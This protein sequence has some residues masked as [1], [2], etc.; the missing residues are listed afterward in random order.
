MCYVCVAQPQDFKQHW[1]FGRV[2]DVTER[3]GGAP[4]SSAVRLVQSSAGFYWQWWW[5]VSPSKMTSDFRM[6]WSPVWSIICVL[7]ASQRRNGFFEALKHFWNLCGLQGQ[8]WILC[9]RTVLQYYMVQV[10]CITLWRDEIK[11]D[12][13]FCCFLRQIVLYLAIERVSVWEYF[14]MWT[15][16]ASNR[17][18]TQDY[19]ATEISTE[20]TELHYSFNDLPTVHV[21]DS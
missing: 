17:T 19:E 15:G 4:R 21:V 8:V 6:K 2:P 9:M 12:V 3:P 13:L 10:K 20:L 7:T 18:T 1:G 14:N 16:G 5:A 11:S